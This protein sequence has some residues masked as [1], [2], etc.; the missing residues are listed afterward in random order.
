MPVGSTSQRSVQVSGFGDYGHLTP[1]RRL[2]RF[3]FVRPAFCLGLPSD[4]Q[5][6]AT[7]LPLANTSPC[8]V[9]RGLSPP[10]RPVHHHSEPNS[11]SHGATRHAWRTQKK[12]WPRPSLSGEAGEGLVYE[13]LRSAAGAA[14]WA[15]RADVETGVV[16]PHPARRV[17]GKEQRF[18][19]WASGRFA[20]HGRYSNQGCSGTRRGAIMFSGRRMSSSMASSSK[21]SSRTSSSTPRP[22]SSAVL[23]MRVAFS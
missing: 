20:V 17:Q 5:S 14:R 11:A 12:G 19:L 4:S 9:C 18:D 15:H 21:P 1:L 22:V 3:L 10:S 16:R 13:S 23:A 6:P 7:P 2:I 8:R